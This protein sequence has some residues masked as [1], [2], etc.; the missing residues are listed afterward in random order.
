MCILDVFLYINNFF[1]LIF[2]FAHIINIEFFSDLIE[3]LHH[4][5]E[6]AELG[7]REQLHCIQTV[8][9]ILSGQ[10]EALNIDPARFYKHLYQII[11]CVNAGKNHED[12]ESIIVTLENVLIKRRKNITQQRYLAFLKRLMTLSLQLLHNGSLGCM[13]LV[14]NAM[15]LNSM[16]DILLDTENKIGSGKFDP[17]INDPEFCNSNCT[18]LFELT[19]LQRHYHSV[20]SK[21]AKY[22]LGGCQVQKGSEILGSET[23]K[24]SPLELFNHYNSNEMAFNPAIP[25]PSS[26]L[27]TK[28]VKSI[29]WNELKLKDLKEI[30]LAKTSFEPNT[31]FDF[32]K[33]FK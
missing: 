24:L 27:F 12:T 21:M 4:L 28:E 22:I 13:A 29:T 10:G 23:S 3:V 26:Q 30:C 32:F 6:N 20:V 17:T 31:K 7:Y 1:C 16:L 2:R 33:E 18:S 25:A 11:L 9:A 19:L 8:F 5:I 14:K 15:Q